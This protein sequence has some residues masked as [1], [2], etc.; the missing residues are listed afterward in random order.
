[1]KTVSIILFIFFLAFAVVQYNDPDAIFWSVVYA[2]TS[3][4][5]LL[6]GFG[7]IYP[8]F[9]Y[10]GLTAYSIGILFLL[11]EFISWIRSGYPSITDSMQAE[12]PEIEVVR[13]FLGLIICALSMILLF[14]SKK[15]IREQ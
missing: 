5:F 11:P 7:R 14:F 3:I 15:L 6:R 13:E 8:F 12:R 2:Y 10:F 4:L 1:M 9:I